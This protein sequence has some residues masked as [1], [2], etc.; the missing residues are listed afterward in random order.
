MAAYRQHKGV[1]FKS[2]TAWLQLKMQH[3]DADRGELRR[4]SIFKYVVYQ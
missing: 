2:K 1:K 3:G 4:N